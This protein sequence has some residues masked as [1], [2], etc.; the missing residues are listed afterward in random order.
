MKLPS[1]W[2]RMPL[3]ALAIA[4]FSAMI[5]AVIGLVSGWDAVGYSNG[6]FVGGAVAIA[7][8]ILSS[9]G[10]WRNRSDFQQMYS[11]SAGDMALAE[12]TR[13]WVHD[14]TRGY[15]A[16]LLMSL[17]GIFLIGFSILIGSFMS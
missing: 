17:V 13:L 12:R 9:F 11:Q 15:N 8:A 16:F 7:A 14:M 4:L 1:L 6:M 3:T 5:I 2:V 10:G